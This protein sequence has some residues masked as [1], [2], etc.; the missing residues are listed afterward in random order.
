MLSTIYGRFSLL[1][2]NNA[3]LQSCPS[4][5]ERK[6]IQR[7]QRHAMICMMSSRKESNSNQLFSGR[8]NFKGWSAK[9]INSK[10]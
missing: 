8:N 6:S 7:R 2:T 10:T 5:I 3:S 1:V 9:A 4:P